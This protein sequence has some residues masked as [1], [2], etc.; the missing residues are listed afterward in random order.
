VAEGKPVST[1]DVL[2]AL[3]RLGAKIEALPIQ[4]TPEEARR[5]KAAL[6]FC[7]EMS[8][9]EL[10]MLVRVRVVGRKEMGNEE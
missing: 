10:E 5:I 6:A 9:E 1:A 3:E 2:A 8:T 7:V 4:P